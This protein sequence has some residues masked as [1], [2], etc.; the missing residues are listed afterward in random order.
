MS[1]EWEAENVF[2]V[3]GS[4]ISRQILALSSRQPLSATELAEHCEVSEPTIYRRISAL[5]E[6]DMLDEQQQ[7]DDDG[8]HY[9]QF[10]AN[11]ERVQLHVAEGQFDIDIQLKKSYTD[12]FAGFWNDLEN[13]TEDVS[14][15]IHSLHLDGS[16]SGVSG[17]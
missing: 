16:P 5:Q 10:R 8:H 17:E 14:M 12:K 11:L 15:D 3:L 6:Y 2:D 4:E 7:I 13:G 1:K 9:K